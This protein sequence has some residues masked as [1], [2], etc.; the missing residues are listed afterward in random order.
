MNSGLPWRDDRIPDPDDLVVP[1]GDDKVKA[2]KIFVV[3]A[4]NAPALEHGIKQGQ[5]Y[6]AIAG[7]WLAQPVNMYQRF[8]PLLASFPLYYSLFKVGIR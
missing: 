5:V 3:E 4:P 7:T 2:R 8:I 1:S 6:L